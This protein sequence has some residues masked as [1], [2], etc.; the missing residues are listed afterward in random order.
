VRYEELPR[1]PTRFVLSLPREN[2]PLPAAGEAR[3][4]SNGH[5][6]SPRPN[7]H[8]TGGGPDR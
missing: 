2:G 5:H 4:E 8:A 1:G 3:P 7:S 6:A